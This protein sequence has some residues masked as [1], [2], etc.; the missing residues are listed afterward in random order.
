MIK[1]QRSYH[2]WIIVRV[3]VVSNPEK[4]AQLSHFPSWARCTSIP[5]GYLTKSHFQANTSLIIV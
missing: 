4:D 3:K 2:T 1:L 5:R